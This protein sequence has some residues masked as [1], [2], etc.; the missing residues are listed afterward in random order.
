MKRFLV[1]LMLMFTL[2]AFAGIQ[3]NQ[4]DNAGWRNL[5]EAQKAAVMKQVAETAAQGSGSVNTTNVSEWVDVGERIGKM[6]GG[7]AKEVGVAVNDFVKTPVGKMAMVVIVW[8]F[9]GNVIIH[10]LGGGVVL[11]VGLSFILYMLRRVRG[12]TY[13]YSPDKTDIFR[14]A[15]LMRVE[16]EPL[17]EN[18]AAGYTA[19]AALVLAVS[20]FTAFSF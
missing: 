17:H 16:R 6:I 7:V 19:A 3:S 11:V 12:V 9:M 8:H 15:R 14:R 13:Q 1:V 10:V 18:Y 4:L 20:L 5:S 2:P